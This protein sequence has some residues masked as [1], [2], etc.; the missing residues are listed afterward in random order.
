[1]VK[2]EMDTVY[3]DD[4]PVLCYAERIKRP[5]PGGGE[6]EVVDIHIGDNTVR[7]W[8]VNVDQLESLAESLKEIATQLRK[9]A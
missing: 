1:M 9:D 4:F 3:E 7:L 2:I 6:T 5:W 8:P